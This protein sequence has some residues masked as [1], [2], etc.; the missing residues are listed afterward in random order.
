MYNVFNMGVRVELY[1]ESEL[2][3][4]VIKIANGF[5]IDAQVIGS[6]EDSSNSNN[7]VVVKSENRTFEYNLS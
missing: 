3:D 6:V 5:S 1:L 7:E 4:Q 2:A